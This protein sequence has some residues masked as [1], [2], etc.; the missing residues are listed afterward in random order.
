MTFGW[1]PNLPIDVM[2][3]KPQSEAKNIP[4]YVKQTQASMCMAILEVRQTNR[5]A[6]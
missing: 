1:T 6:I 2:L 3:G 5:E 4:D